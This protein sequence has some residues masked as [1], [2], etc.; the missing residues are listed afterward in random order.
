MKSSN[1]QPVYTYIVTDSKGNKVV[2]GDK[3]ESGSVLTATY[4]FD[5]LNY[6]TISVNS[7]IFDNAVTFYVAKTTGALQVATTTYWMIF[8]ALVNEEYLNANGNILWDK[9]DLIQ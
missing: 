6:G 5:S 2:D 8:N 7:P 1:D 4:T 9:M 3:I